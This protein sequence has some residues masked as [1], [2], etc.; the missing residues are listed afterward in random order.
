M[1]TAEDHAFNAAPLAGGAGSILPPPVETN[2]PAPPRVPLCARCK[3]RPVTWD[4]RDGSRALCSPCYLSCAAC[5][6]HRDTRHR[7]RSE[8]CQACYRKALK[9]LQG[10]LVDSTQRQSVLD[11]LHKA[12][13]NLTAELLTLEDREARAKLNFLADRIIRLC[14]ALG[15]PLPVLER[16]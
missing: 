10:I 16:P 14:Q 8:L 9:A 11:A 15:E 4:R 3:E 12:R 7:A 2:T 6:R 13:Q 1:T 5:G